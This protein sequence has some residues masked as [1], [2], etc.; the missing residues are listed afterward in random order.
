MIISY[1]ELWLGVNNI[2]SPPGSL[3][4]EG[5]GFADGGDGVEFLP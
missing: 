1:P 3:D 2:W 4:V 5:E